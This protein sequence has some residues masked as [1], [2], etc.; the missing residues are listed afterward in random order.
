MSTTGM[1]GFK[2]IHWKLWE[3]LITTKHIQTLYHKVWR[4]DGRTDGQTG[5]NLNAPWLSSRGHNKQIINTVT[6]SDTLFHVSGIFLDLMHHTW[7]SAS[8]VILWS[9]NIHL[10]WYNGSDHLTV[11]I[12]CMYK[13]YGIPFCAYLHHTDLRE[14]TSCQTASQCQQRH[15]LCYYL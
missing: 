15:L 6:W 5:A 12:M 4:T 10:T 7:R 13:W 9:R 2:K 3:E 8:H 1:Q 11:V 14:S